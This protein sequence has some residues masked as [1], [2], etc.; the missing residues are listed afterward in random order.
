M[1][2]A[3][4]LPDAGAA[5]EGSLEALV[6][7]KNIHRPPTLDTLPAV[8]VFARWCGRRGSR[9]RLPSAPHRVGLTAGPSDPLDT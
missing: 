4:R 8:S 1:P 5:A 3:I 9:L 2:K 6:H 7:A